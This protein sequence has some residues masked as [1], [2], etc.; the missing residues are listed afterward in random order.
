MH[1]EYILLVPCTDVPSPIIHSLCDRAAAYHRQTRRN[2][3]IIQ[4]PVGWTNGATSIC[5]SGLLMFPGGPGGLGAG[6]SAANTVRS[7]L[8]QFEQCIDQ[9]CPTNLVIFRFVNKERE[10]YDIFE[11][12]AE[13]DALV[14]TSLVANRM[15]RAVR[16]ASK[17]TKAS[18][19]A[20]ARP[21]AAARAL[22]AA[23]YPARPRL[24]ATIVGSQ[25]Y[26]PCAVDPV[27]GL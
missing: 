7:A 8:G 24:A 12:A 9:S 1:A 2:G 20:G 26:L 4:L 18:P 19:P 6:E 3:F 27:R 16:V 14:V 22:I 23:L 21:D 17:V 25:L 10:V 5:Q 11:K 13:E 15:M